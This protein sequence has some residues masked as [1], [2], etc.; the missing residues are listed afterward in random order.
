MKSLSIIIILILIINLQAPVMAGGLLATPSTFGYNLNDTR[1]VSG[2]FILENIGNVDMNVT[3]EGKRL[4]MDNIHL[5]FADSGI[6]NWITINTPANFILKPGE[7]KA[8]PFTINAPSQFSYNDALGA[9]TANGVPVLSEGSQPQFGVQQAIQLVITIVAGIPGP[10]IESLELLE[11]DA[12][13]VLISYMPGDFM[14]HVRN[15]GTVY[16]NMTG[17]IEISGL[18]G[19][20]KI[21]IEG[22]VFPE[23][24]YYLKA[25]WVPGFAE[26]G[27]Y[28]AKTVINYGRY[29]QD[30][31]LVTN[32]TIFVIPVW[33]IIILILALAVWIIRKKEI[34]S[35]VKIKIER[36]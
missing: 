24:D 10:I 18:I 16:A 34:G 1:T 32:N 23:D 8:V 26:F 36:K 29:R 14:Y 15:N 11:H 21:P 5:E 30:K 22:G 6:A 27:I 25:Q 35:P 12:P 33:L 28:N 31:T 7:K 19:G 9:I 4:L 13:V 2:Q 17:N 20:Q 3:L